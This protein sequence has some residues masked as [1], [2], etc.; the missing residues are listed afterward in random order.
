MKRNIRKHTQLSLIN[1]K[2]AGRPAKVD[3][4]IRHISREKISKPSALHLTIKVRENKADIKNKRILKA[5]H[6]AIKR[7]RLQ[8]MKVLHYTL[9]YNHL[10]ILVEVSNNKIL[11]KGMQALGISLSKAINKIKNLKGTVYK[12]RYHF[13]KLNSRREMKNALLYIFKNGMKHKRACSLIDPYNSFVAEKRISA[14]M[15]N[16]ILSSRFL[17]NLKAELKNILDIGRVFYLDLNYLKI[18]S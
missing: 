14:D 10:H 1:P 17:S 6:H 13:R 4:G 2:R 5:L 8:N 3:I 11:H 9:E 12:H 18:T 7:A 16:T 15:Q